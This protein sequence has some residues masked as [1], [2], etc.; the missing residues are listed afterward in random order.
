[1]QPGSPEQTQDL[2]ATGEAQL[3]LVAGGENGD[4]DE[5]RPSPCDH[6]RPQNIDLVGA[7]TE[8]SHVIDGGLP[9]AARVLGGDDATA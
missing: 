2:G 5:T 3:D 4:S 9:R 7:G 1:V 8:R 6:V